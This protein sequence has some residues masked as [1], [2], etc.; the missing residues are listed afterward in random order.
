MKF[1]LYLKNKATLLN[2]ILNFL[3]NT[4]NIIFILLDQ[5]IYSLIVVKSQ[6][7]D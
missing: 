2:W 3:T 7:L 6:V 1:N 4:L 5:V